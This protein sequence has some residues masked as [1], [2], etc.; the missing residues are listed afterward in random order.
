MENFKLRTT[1]CTNPYIS[2]QPAITTTWADVELECLIRKHNDPLEPEP[3]YL[4]MDVMLP[5]NH[6]AI[7]AIPETSSGNLPLAPGEPRDA[8]G[9][10][11]QAAD[12]VG[13]CIPQEL[14]PTCDARLFLMVQRDGEITWCNV[15]SSTQRREEVL[16]ALRTTDRTPSLSETGRLLMH[17]YDNQLVTWMKDNGVGQAWINACI[18]L[19]AEKQD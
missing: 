7:E 13:S 18:R 8:Q 19:T 16:E 14:R 4:L 15:I 2:A 9:T 5:S 3:S 10:F 6:I 1:R 11:R 17:Y 12:L